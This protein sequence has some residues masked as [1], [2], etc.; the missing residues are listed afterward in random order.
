MKPTL[1]KH[2]TDSSTFSMGKHVVGKTRNPKPEIRRKSELRNPK[3][4]IA[5]PGTRRLFEIGTPTQPDG[6]NQRRAATALL[7]SD[8]CLRISDF[9]RISVFGFRIS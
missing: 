6:F 2:N 9:L 1:L 5:A 8:F 7:P 3:T 4:A